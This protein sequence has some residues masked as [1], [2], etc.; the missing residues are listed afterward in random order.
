[1]KKI[2]LLTFLLPLIAFSQPG[3]QINDQK[4]KKAAFEKR[5][6]E[7]LSKP[8]TEPIKHSPEAKSQTN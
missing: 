1:M 3:K 8:A 5:I 7:E 6:T 4:M 2:L